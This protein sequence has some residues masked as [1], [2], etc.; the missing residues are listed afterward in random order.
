MP[1]TASQKIDNDSWKFKVETVPLQ[2]PD[3]K[4]TSWFANRRVDNGDVLGVCSQRYAVVDNDTLISKAE[5]A[6]ARKGMTDYERKVY[7]T[8]GGAKMRVVY[9]FN[10]EDFKMKV[11]KVNDIMGYRLTLQNS[12]DRSLRVSFALGF[13]RLV[14]TNGMQ[15][16]EKDISMVKKHSTS[17]NLGD[18]LTDS[19]IDKSLAQYKN[20]MGTFAALAGLQM[21][22]EQG[23]NILQNYTK[24]NIL[25]EKLREGIAQV[26]NNPL[27]SH[28]DGNV[29]EKRNGY[30]FYNA[31]TRF[32]TSDDHSDKEGNSIGTLESTR[33]EL[34]NRT[35][36]NVLKS[37]NRAVATPTYFGKLLKPV[38][39]DSIVIVE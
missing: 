14:C 2:T 13:L 21:T 16:L 18:L 29:N 31:V 25:S 8:E 28:N 10:G 7:V 27:E 15:T 26:W 12:F 5:D 9:D 11:P 19:A 36:T 17:L 24:S 6:F 39:D 3:G 30:Q 34:S 1:I 4:K 23:L 20:A 37:L 35:S 32:L 38:T 22:Q 33:F